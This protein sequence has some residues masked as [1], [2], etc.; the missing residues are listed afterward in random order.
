MKVLGIHSMTHD[1]GVCLYRGGKIGPAI[2]EERLSRIKHHPGIEVEGKPPLMSL[3]W[4]LKDAKLQLEDI[5]RFVHVGWEGEKFMK[6]DLARSRFREFAKSIDPDGQKT[7]FVPHHEAHAASAYYASGFEDA[8]VLVVD[9]AGD[10]ASTSLY[11]GEGRKL[12]KVQEYPFDQSLGYLYSRAA[13]TIGLGDF[14][15]G[16]GKMTALAAYGESIPGF[17]SIIRIDDGKYT[18]SPDYR[19][20]FK[21][22]GHGSGQ[23]TPAHKDFAYTVQTAL[24]IAIIELL[25]TAHKTYG[26]TRIAFAG[27]VAL[28]CRLN[29]KIGAMPWVE[30]FFVQP[31]AND[32]G[33]CLGAA[34]LGAVAGGGPVEKMGNAYLGPGIAD[35]QAG[36]YIEDNRLR[37]RR[38]ADAAKTCAELVS[39]GKSVAFMHGKLEFGPRALGHRSLL[40]DPRNPDV[41]D[42][43]NR[44]KQREP[45][46]PV[47]PAIIESEKQY[48][49]LSKASEFMTKAIPMNDLAAR[50]IPGALHVDRTA[51]VQAVRDKEDIFYR[52]IQEFE[53][54]SG[55]PAILNTSLNSK[56]EPLCTTIEEGVKFFFST[57]TQYLIVGDWLIE[58]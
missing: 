21:P 23:L 8:L 37:G 54:I 18:I 48:C 45:W 3:R 51:R 29:G 31:A 53:H 19:E 4:A 52:V 12:Q 56:G 43:L 42:E 20:H 34:Y 49:D 58:K 27:G 30:D 38:L 50:E 25:Q 1:C 40:G 55:I 33:L 28:N 15:F 14:G 46:R 39:Q 10:W 9:G 22:Y 44:I 35:D 17:P 32:C 24:E 36:Q 47:A 2:E 7:S 11:V 6:L 41:R 57:P 13:K 16:E 5:D 26:K